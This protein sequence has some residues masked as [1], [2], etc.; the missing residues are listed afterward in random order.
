M[1]P[2]LV[3]CRV[4]GTE[5]LE[6]RAETAGRADEAREAR[7]QPSTSSV[8]ERASVYVANRAPCPICGV[9]QSTTNMRRNITRIHGGGN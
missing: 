6:A 1:R 4:C 7:G 2:G 3:V 8:P 5:I 9:E